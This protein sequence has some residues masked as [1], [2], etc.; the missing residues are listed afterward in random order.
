MR[1]MANIMIVDD[2][3]NVRSS[4]RRVMEHNNHE[5][6]CEAENGVIALDLYDTYKPDIVTMDIAMKNGNG[7]SAIKKILN[8]DP[9][10]RIVVISALNDEFTIREALKSGVLSFLVKPPDLEN[11]VKTIENIVRI[12][13]NE[14]REHN[15]R[16]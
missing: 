3:E 2:C 15:N 8:H 10:A 6:I 9:E 5:V 7:L 1:D 13:R 14:I 16:L 4:L 11:V 12:P